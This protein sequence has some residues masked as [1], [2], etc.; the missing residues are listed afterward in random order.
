MRTRPSL[1]CDKVIEAGWLAAVIVVPLF[2]NIYSQRVFEPDKLSILRSIALVMSAAWLVRVAE[3]S[4][5]GRERPEPR[6]PLRQRVFKTPMVLPTLLLVVVYLLSTVLS[7]DWQVS[8]MGSYQ[9][10]QGTYTTLSYIVIFFLML[11]GLRTNRQ[12]NRLIMV[13]VLVSFPI[14]MYGLIQHFGLDPL[15][16]GGD[17]TTRVASNMGNA[18]FVAAFLILTVPLTLSRLFENWRGAVGPFDSRDAILGVVAFLLLAAALLVGMFVR[19][20]EDAAWI[21]WVALA[22]GVGLQV[23]IYLLSPPERRPRVLAISLPLTFAFLVA[24]SWILEIFFPP[25][26]GS[27]A[28]RYFWLGILAAIVFVLAMAAFAAYLRKPVSRLLLLAGYFVILISQ[29]IAI[30]YA[31]SRGPLLGLLGGVSVYFILLGVT[32]RRLWLSWLVAGLAILLGVF[33]IMFNTVQSPLIE[34]LRETPYV[35]RLGRVLQTE[36]GTG[37]VRVLIWEGVTDMLAVHEP[38]EFPGDDGGPDGLNALRPI[39]GYGPESMYVAYNSFYPPE[40]GQFEKRNASPDRSHNET[41]DALVITG[42]LGFVAYMLVFTSFFYFGLKW[43]G[44]I[45]ERWQKRAFLGLWTLGGAVGAVATWA[46]RGPVYVGVGIPVGVMLGLMAYIL[47]AVLAATFRPGS[48]WARGGSHWLWLL[49]L[50]S[51]VVAHFIEIHFGIAIAATRT[52]FWVYAAMLV[53]IGIRLAAQTAEAEQVTVDSAAPAEQVNSEPRRRRRGSA[54]KP[55][56]EARAAADQDW[57][58]SLLVLS[59]L[60]ILI[61]GT[62]LFNSITIQPERTGLL[63]TIWRSLTSSRGEPSVVMLVLF[64]CTWGMAGLVSLSDLATRD[65][66]AGRGAWDWLGAVGISVLVTF[67]VLLVF[68]LMHAARL[69][70]VTI[71]SPD[72]PNPLTHTIT[73]FYLFVLLVML[74]L[75][76]VLTFMF[77]RRTREWAWTGALA[78]IGVIALAV[79]LALAVGALVIATN[80]SIVRADIFYK[81]GLSAEKARQWDGAIYFYERA[82]ELAGEQDFY[83]LFLGRAYMEKGKSSPEE[84]RDA[85]L[86]ESEEALLEARR[87]APLNTDH[88]ANL[89]RLHRTWGGLSE[90][91]ERTERLNK[92]LDYYKDATSLSPH[93]AQLLNEWAQAYLA[94]GDTPHAM[95]K[96]DESLA[97]DSEFVQTYLLLGEYYM[98]QQEWDKALEMYQKAVQVSPK[99]VDAYSSLAFVSTQ[100]GDLDAALEAYQKAVELRP[101]NY[102]NRK[103][104]A[105]VYQQMGRTEDAIR[106]AT[107]ALELAPENQKEAVQSLLAQL[108]AQQPDLPPMETEQV[109]QLMAEGRSSMDAKDWVAAEE[110]FQQVLE[111]DPNNGQAHSALAYLYARQ[112]RLDDAVAENLIVVSLLPSDYNSHKNLA[113]LYQEMGALDDAIASGE[114]A[115]ALAPE[116]DRPALQTFLDQVRQMQGETAPEAEIKQRAGDLMPAQ[117]AN[118]YSA[119]PPMSIDPAKSYRATL[120]TVKGNIV[121]DLAAADAPQTVNNFVFLSGEG[122]YDGLTFHRVENSPGFSLIQGGDPAGTGRGGPG[123][124]VPAEIGLPHDEGAIATAR[125]GDQVNPSRASSGS[126]FYIGLVPI[127][128]LDDG[129]TVFGYIV[130][131]L[132][133]AKTIAVGDEILKVVITEK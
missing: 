129:Y 20:G 119:P 123:Y 58:G 121:V 89:A 130:E 57:R 31:Q 80:L 37:R 9:R 7:V 56:P 73:F 100:V 5:A 50:F 12:L 32:N 92:S 61:L 116:A 128:Q 82:I 115:L 125:L 13:P 114:R 102:N 60:V 36:E 97:L 126:Q 78:D 127:H 2:F 101:R 40:L 6:V 109:Q 90:G 71:T 79:T 99:A 112:G 24:F 77:W 54:Q 38:I 55:K 17:V 52:Y 98:R 68:A 53:V 66:S 23:P 67:A 83:Y 48:Q 122:F 105:I 95:E 33:L 8:L 106:E 94:L 75:A 25:A 91:D 15:P 34:T 64:L 72:A 132:D 29:I 35:G 87:I 1:F 43:L 3:D 22:V 133:V 39:I 103:N 18:I 120:E 49:A 111:L 65:E 96:F 76:A 4:R 10:L 21:R 11:D 27:D 63:G 117:R 16:W 93:N 62:M 131:G 45:A 30:F 113:L 46:W 42:L 108:G 70:P 81:Q 84:E 28:S 26:Q 41:F 118:M 110:S 14:A 47:V 104:L 86:R 19:R 107:R 88:S 69:E 124:T 85:W 44:L 59:L 51:A 74:A